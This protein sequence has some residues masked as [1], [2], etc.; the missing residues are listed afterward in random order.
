M[1]S[2]YSRILV[3]LDISAA[4][5]AVLEYIRPLARLTHAKLTLIHV[6]DGF[7]ARNQQRLGESEEMRQDRDYLERRTEELRGEGFDA[8]AVLAC[9]EPVK[10]IIACAD[11][12][13]YDLI[14]MGTHGHRFPADL[15]L[16]SVASG[17]RHSTTIP[18]LLVP[19]KGRPR[20]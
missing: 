14:A 2:L 6:A 3:P 18:I 11:R 5:E 10:E 13:D 19:S 1:T 20:T 15:I 4:D 7:M 12:G 17:V 8:D 9:G 16:G